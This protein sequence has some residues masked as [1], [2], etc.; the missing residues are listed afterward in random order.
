M[1]NGSVSNHPHLAHNCKGFRSFSS[2]SPLVS[3][4]FMTMGAYGPPLS[5]HPA[6]EFT[7]SPHFPGGS[8]IPFQSPSSVFPSLLPISGIR[9]LCVLF[10][11]LWFEAAEFSS[12]VWWQLSLLSHPGP[13]GLPAKPCLP[14]SLVIK[15]SVSEQC[16]AS[17][18]LIPLT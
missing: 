9:V 16:I 2:I 4:L 15:L 5:T 14:A 12:P 17:A 1:F 8:A 6:L 18:I 11:L 10:L 7:P 3:R 13:Q